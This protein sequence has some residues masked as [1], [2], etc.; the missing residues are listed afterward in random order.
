MALRYVLPLLAVLI[1]PLA[2]AQS[3]EW[4]STGGPTAPIDQL[5][6]YVDGSVLGLSNGTLFS[7]RDDGRSWQHVDGAP[8]SIRGLH[9]QQERLWVILGRDRIESAPRLGAAWEQRGPELN[10]WIN[11]AVRDDAGFVTAKNQADRIYRSFDFGATW[12]AVV[13]DVPA[14]FEDV[15]FDETRSLQIL[16]NGMLRRTWHVSS[17]AYEESYFSTDDGETWKPTDCG[18]LY[19]LDEAG[20]TG[21]VASTPIYSE[22]INGW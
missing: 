6:L 12:Q 17:S 14:K 18:S 3:F 1:A 22:V 2:A 8:A 4:Q 19:A 13:H 9:V 20:E 11:L 5:K 21:F 16:P 7:S 10:G 15:P